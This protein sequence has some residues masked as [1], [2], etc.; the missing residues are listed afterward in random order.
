[1]PEVTVQQRVDRLEMVMERLA[2][3]VDR[4]SMAVERLSIEMDRFRDEMDKF[5]D[6][7]GKFRDKMDKFGDEMKE[8]KDEMRV[9]KDEVRA[10]MR[11]F[12]QEM[13]RRWGDLADRLG[14]LVEDI[15][16]PAV[17]DVIERHFER[18]VDFIAVRLRRKREELRGEYDVVAT[19]GDML[20]VVEVKSRFGLEQVQQF[21]E[22][23]DR[24]RGLFPEYAEK[25]IMGIIASLR[26]EDE[27]VQEATHR[28]FYAMAMKGEYMDLLNAEELMGKREGGR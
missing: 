5:R 1:M 27:V 26:L 11:E 25:R 13:N 18:E 12:K 19:A 16:A 14:T 10:E 17:P 23:L 2:Y 7:M 3:Q 8:F 9:F 6:E 15:V 4:T 22:K 20:F 21:Q 24:F 28:G